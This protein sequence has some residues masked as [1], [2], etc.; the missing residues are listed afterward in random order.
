[1]ILH[2]ISDRRRLAPAA[3]EAVAER[4]LL[5]QARFAVDAAIDFVQVRE[6]DLESGPLVRLVAACLAITKGTRTRVI[7]NDRLDVALAAGADGVHLRADSMDA[8]AVRRCAPSPFLVGRSVHSPEEAEA[9]GPVDYLIAGT[10]WPT[11][12]KPHDVGTIG[13]DGLS[14]ICRVA[15]VPVLA[16]GGVDVERS[17]AVASA[18]AAGVAAIGVFIGGDTGRCRAVGLTAVARRL[19]DGFDTAGAHS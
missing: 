14:A 16:I 19:R 13:I 11:T 1:M 15:R 7:V 6:R 2:L 17:A 8:A 10:V 9:A 4:C 12:S 18:G 3:A 5:T